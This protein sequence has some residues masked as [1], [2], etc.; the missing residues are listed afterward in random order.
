[1]DISKHFQIMLDYEMRANRAM[2]DA[3][4]AAVSPP[5][6]AVA[7]FAHI[8]AARELWIKRL[9]H[10][11]TDGF[12][13]FPA[14]TLAEQRARMEKIDATWKEL[15]AQFDWARIE[16]PVEYTDTRGGRWRTR[17]YDALSNLVTHSAYHRGQIAILLRHFGADPPVVDY[18]YFQRERL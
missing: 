9:R 16:E 12:D 17:L 1:M 3:M 7:F 6:R 2:L 14:W 18:L 4:E 11:S 5:E 13:P 10:E 15:T 8:L